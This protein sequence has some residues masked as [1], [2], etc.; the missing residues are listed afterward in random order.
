M[1]KISIETVREETEKNGW[2]LLSEEYINL[3]TEMSFECSEGHKIY[4]SWEKTRNKFSCPVCKT[5]RFIKMENSIKPKKKGV[6]RVLALDQAT[7]ITGFSIFDDQKLIYYGTFKTMLNDEIARDSAIKTWLLSMLDN[8]KPD[9]V[10]V[11]G[12]Q[13]EENHGVT[14]FETLARLQGILLE[15][16]FWEKIPYKICPTNTWR[17]H[18][19]VK[20][21][22]RV[23][24]K[25]SMQKI[26]K[27]TFDVSVTDDEADAIGIGKF[28]SETTCPQLK[29]ES[30]E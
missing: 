2:K 23:D 4:A 27:E 3:K 10:G 15:T 1:A 21:R 8:W 22:S 7:K 13:Y 25:R 17:H 28:V 19:G 14:V 16:L 18:C 20:G 24:K 29:I 11:E 30:W 6:H 9:I 12:L 5:N 26:V